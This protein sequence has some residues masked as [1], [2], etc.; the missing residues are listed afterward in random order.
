MNFDKESKCEKKIM[1]VCVCVCVGGGYEGGG[2]IREYK[3]YKSNFEFSSK[4]ILIMNPNLKNK[5]GGGGGG[6]GGGGMI[7][8]SSSRS[9]DQKK[10]ILY[11]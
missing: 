3:P 6:G 4:E 1:C 7:M 9:S 11:I 8:V 2:R 5:F 10:K